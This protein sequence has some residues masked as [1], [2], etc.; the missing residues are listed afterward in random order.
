MKEEHAPISPSGSA[1]LVQCSAS[2]SL[3]AM[4]PEVADSP[5]AAEGIAAHWA[6]AEMLQG[7]LVDINDRAPNGM[8][9][10]QEM[11]EG[12]DLYYDD[13]LTTLQQH[14]LTLA[15][16]AVEA[17]VDIARIHPQ[18]WGTPDARAWAI[19]RTLFLW[20]FKFGHRT[21][22]VFENWQ[23]AAYAAG[24]ISAT[25]LIDA[26]VNVVARIVQPRSFH[27]DGPVREWRFNGAD[28]RA[29]INILSNAAHE[30]LGPNPKARVGPECRDCRARHA[31]PTLQRAA[32]GACDV[33]GAAEP[34]DLP[35]AALG[36]ELRQLR[37]AQ[38][39]LEAR[40][41]GLE[42]QAQARIKSGA[43]VPGWRVEHGAGRE[44]WKQPAAEVIAVGQMLGVSLAK[45]VEA[46]TPKQAAKA[47]LL[48]DVVAAMSET[49]RG[50]AALVEDDGSRARAVFGRR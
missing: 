11:V 6:G 37:R 26:E 22:E 28:I 36:L 32:Q 48:P 20:D 47:G 5:D 12:A 3:Q 34:F 46:I 18:C 38:T 15:D 10:T 50:G 40:L 31:C 7:R 25:N 14:G 19:P 33:A 24:C 4:F 43:Q 30:A 21:V 49:P 16:L 1:R 27:R 35:P 42:E 17:P 2:V 23:L 9:L 29:H 41:S 44:R 45:P 8:F 39:L 13:V